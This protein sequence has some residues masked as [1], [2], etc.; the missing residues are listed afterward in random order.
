MRPWA[1]KRDITEGFMAIK[2]I[3]KEDDVSFS[4]FLYSAT[5]HMDLMVGVV[6]TITGVLETVLD[7]E[8]NR[9]T[10]GILG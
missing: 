3:Q 4:F 8:V 10:V 2:D 1:T 9:Y 5:W 6:K 7:F